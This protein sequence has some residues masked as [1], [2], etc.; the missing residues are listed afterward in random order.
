[1]NPRQ[2][3]TGPYSIDLTAQIDPGAKT[4]TI[5]KSGTTRFY[6]L[7]SSTGYTLSAPTI[8]G[9]NVVMSYQ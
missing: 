6:R 9:N 7:R 8:A 5:P 1:L 2:Q 3:V 4:V